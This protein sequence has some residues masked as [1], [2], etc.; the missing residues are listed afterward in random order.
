MYS[1]IG[2]L[3]VHRRLTDS[4]AG[5]LSVGTLVL[6]CALGRS[7]ITRAKREGDGATPRAVLPM[8]RVWYRAD[9][10]PRPLT[11]LPVRAIRAGDGWCDAPCDRNYN[12]P[13]RLP[14]PASHEDM[15][16]EDG[17]YDLVVELGWNDD[18][19]RPGRGSAIFMHVARAG[20]RP[21]E[22]CIALRAADLRRLLRRIGPQT[23]IRVSG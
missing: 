3:H 9:R 18:P 10:G 23:V 14:Y 11:G 21:T 12:R 2:S 17:L 6:P 15:F 22:G 8:R 5:W 1:R 13:V 16:R 20:F 4:S 19:P 7:G